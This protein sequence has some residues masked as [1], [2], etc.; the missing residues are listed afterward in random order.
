MMMDWQVFISVRV[1]RVVRVGLVQLSSTLPAPVAVPE[2]LHAPGNLVVILP[3]DTRLA[4]P[5]AQQDT[6][7]Y[8]FGYTASLPARWRT[9][10]ISDNGSQADL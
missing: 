1:A 9:Q 10:R 5:T 4:C 8:A 2:Q 3:R 7:L 6:S